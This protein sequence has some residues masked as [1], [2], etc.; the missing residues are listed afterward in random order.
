MNNESKKFLKDFLS[1][2]GPSGFEEAS[3]NVWTKRTR[4]YAQSIRRDV[5]GNAIAVLNPKDEYKV[6]L[7]GHCDEIGF[8]ISHITSE[9]YLCV[10]PVGGIDSGVLPGSQVKVQAEKGFVDGVIGKKPIDLTEECD[11]NKSIAIKELL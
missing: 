1:Q 6:L 10:V 11:R 7:A 5:H 9:G 3:Q 8:I 4:A 2:C